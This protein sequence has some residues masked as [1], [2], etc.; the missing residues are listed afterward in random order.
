M[1]LFIFAKPHVSGFTH[2]EIENNMGACDRAEQ[3][4][5]SEDEGKKEM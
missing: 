4:N 1:P 3:L 2:G 5:L